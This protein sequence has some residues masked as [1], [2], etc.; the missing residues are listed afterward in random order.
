VAYT[1]PEDVFLKTYCQARAEVAAW[2]GKRGNAGVVQLLDA[3]QK[4][5]SFTAQYGAMQLP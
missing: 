1:A 2:I 4:G 5:Q 3:V